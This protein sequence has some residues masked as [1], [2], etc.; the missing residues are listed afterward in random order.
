MENYRQRLRDR[1]TALRMTQAQVA[2][3]IGHQTPS[4]IS[5]F[6]VGGLPDSNK[7]LALRYGMAVRQELVVGFDLTVGEFW[8]LLREQGHA[9][10]LVPMASNLTN[11]EQA[12]LRQQHRITFH[13]VDPMVAEELVKHVYYVRDPMTMLKLY[14]S[15][16]KGRSTL[17]MELCQSD[18]TAIF[19]NPPPPYPPTEMFRVEAA[20]MVNEV[21]ALRVVDHQAHATL[22]D[23]NRL[24]F[25]ALT[26]RDAVH[27]LMYGAGLGKQ[28]WVP[29]Q[30]RGAA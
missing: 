4:I 19:M 12:D 21:T 27:E 20:Y 25:S 29:F 26:H 10:G 14:D 1:R 13:P 9:S 15:M 28:Y 22:K 3:A 23:G 5:Q 18:E 6:E 24:S 30:L 17:A 7:S 16:E 11:Q 8:R 2:A